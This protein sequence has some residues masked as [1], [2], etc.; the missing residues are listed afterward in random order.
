MKPGLKSFNQLP[1]LRFLAAIHLWKKCFFLVGY[2]RDGGDIETIIVILSLLTL[3]SRLSMI[4][5]NDYPFP[6]I[7]KAWVIPY[8]PTP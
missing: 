6:N 2:H 5:C 8:Q 3:F 7:F 4:P 1:F